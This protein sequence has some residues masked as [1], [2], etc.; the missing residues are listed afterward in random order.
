MTA[1]SKRRAIESSSSE[2]VMVR[3]LMTTMSGQSLS[4]SFAR[5]VLMAGIT[6]GVCHA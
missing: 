6:I 1:L 5:T 3:T 4:E 2:A